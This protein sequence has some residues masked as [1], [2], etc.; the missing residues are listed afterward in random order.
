M[1]WLTEISNQLAGLNYDTE[2]VRLLFV[3]LL[4]LIGFSFTLALSF[5]AGAL[6]NPLKKRIVEVQANDRSQSSKHTG[7][8]LLQR[9]G[10]TLIPKAEQKRANIAYQLET[11]GYRASRAPALFYGAKLTSFIVAPL[12]ILV[13][14]ALFTHRPVLDD[15]SAALLGGVVAFLV[16]DFWLKWAVRRRQ[17][18][19]RH[20]LP[21]A[22]D[23]MVVCAEAGLGLNAAIMR[24]ADEIGVQHPE[25]ADELQL[26]M[27]QTRAGMDN[28]SA[29]KELER[30]TGVDDIGAFVT[31]LIQ[32]MRFG[33]SIGQSLRVFA[34]DMRDKRLQRA[35]EKAAQLS[36]I[37][38]MPITLCILP[39][40]FL[41]LLGP[42]LLIL[43]KTVAKITAGDGG[44]P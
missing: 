23:L 5:F 17:Q 32:A 41:I 14:I 42:S 3:I 2:R 7:S 18:H 12:L 34:D 21:D 22:L 8:S 40:F 31:T 33:T 37:M 20:A 39:M 35:Q 26:V 44:L 19:L 24:V 36:L 38:L 15:L 13:G 29:L 30:R 10:S 11:A 16:P 9:L 25:L 27:M 28:R 6:L 4:G 43:M 1:A